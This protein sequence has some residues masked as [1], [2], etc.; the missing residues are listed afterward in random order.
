MK[1]AFKLLILINLCFAAFGQ[2]AVSPIVQPHQTFV[3]ASGQ[4]CSLCSLATFAAGTTTPLATFTDSTGTAQN[5]NPIILDASG[6]AEIWLGANSYKFALT[7]QTGALIWT[8]DNV[9]AASILPCSSANAVQTANTAANGLTCDPTITINT[10][11]HTLTVGVLSVDHVTIAASGTPTTWTFDTTTPATAL[12][13]LGT[14]V[15]SFNGRGGPSITPTTGDYT[16]AEVTGCPTVPT[17]FYQSV[18]SGLT[19]RSKLNLISGTNATVSCVDNAG[20]NSTDCTVS[21][22][23]SGTPKTCNAQ[24]C[25][26]VLPD[27][28]AEEWITGAMQNDSGVGAGNPAQTLALPLV[29]TSTPIS[30]ICSALTSGETM[31]DDTHGSMQIVQT[32]NSTSI[33]VQRYRLADHGSDPSQPLCFIVGH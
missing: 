12:A 19:Q 8:A 5:T 23:I 32:F 11:T 25:Y 4:P 24:G 16:C 6:G 28:T 2:V 27:G 20:A 21:A 26:L 17:I 1:R 13:S 31:G 22:S 18:N 33:T 15:T 3:N 29:L 9:N 10:S 14:V 7:D 30:V